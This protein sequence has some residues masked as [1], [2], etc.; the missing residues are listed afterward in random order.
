VAAASTE[1]RA[2][3]VRPG[4]IVAQAR[5]LCPEAV[6]RVGNLDTYAR[7]S[8]EVTHIL[9]AA[10]RRV[11][12]PSAD[13][14]YVDLS[15]GSVKP[16]TAAEAIKNELQRRLGL[17][18]SLGLASS[19]VAA[20]VAS[21]WARP[22][23]LLIVL[24]GY[25]RSFLARQPL[26]FLPD[27]PP[28]LESSLEKAGITTLGE[29][30]AADD[31]ALTA[32]VGASA[33][34]RLRAAAL[35]SDEAPIAASAPPTWIQEETTIRDV[36][37]GRD[38]L[39]QVIVA[40]TERA[41]RRLRPFGLAAGA[42]AVEVRTPGNTLR[43]EECFQPGIDREDA[44]AEVARTLAAPLLDA[45][46]RALGIVVRLRRLAPLSSQRTLFA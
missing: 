40:L 46:T 10:S 11:E 33:G 37:S 16:V 29:I 9:L 20:R 17:D 43:R 24:P 18:A 45:I 14:A 27:L 35:G 22:R 28:H 13:E 30:I 2:R 3:G 34:A 26:S 41:A 5:R 12:R 7:V 1:A 19:R 15:S 38:T 39:A 44:L 31:A 6:F 32:A 8:E 4:Q 42:I 36:R 25:E 21:T 23:G